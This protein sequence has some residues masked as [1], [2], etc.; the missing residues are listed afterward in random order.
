MVKNGQDY[1]PVTNNCQRFC[2]ELEKCILVPQTLESV[3]EA[4]RLISSLEDEI[5]C[6][7][8]WEYLLT[9]AYIPINNAGIW[10]V[11]DLAL[12][13]ID[14]LAI[15]ML[16]LG[17][18]SGGHKLY[19]LMA[20]NLAL[21]GLCGNVN[22]LRHFQRIFPVTQITAEELFQKAYPERVLSKKPV[23]IEEISE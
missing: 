4:G 21:S 3:F 20:L 6:R 5:I 16:Y 11:R 18:R 19:F 13:I 22:I 14:V 2:E 1:N 7:Q 17:L 12:T 8:T 23:K 15:Y 10:P 9:R